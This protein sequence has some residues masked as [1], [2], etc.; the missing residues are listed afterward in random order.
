MIEISGPMNPTVFR[1]GVSDQ[2]YACAGGEWM[3]VPP[4]T[5][6]VDLNWVDDWRK[7]APAINNVVRETIEG[8][9]GDLYTVEVWT[10]GHTKCNCM[11]FLYRRKCKH[12]D[13]LKERV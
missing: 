11:G 5:K 6:L 12:I 13:S 2:W 8:S 9:R 3:E 4:G 7:D 1:S 10:D